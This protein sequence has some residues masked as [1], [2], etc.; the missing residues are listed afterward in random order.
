MKKLIIIALTI[1]FASCENP[2]IRPKYVATESIE[3]S[4]Y[5]KYRLSYIQDI[6]DS[7]KVKL[8]AWI[9]ETM[10]ASSSHLSAGDYED[11]EDLIEEINDIG[12]DLF[13]VKIDVL[14]ILESTN[15][16]W[17]TIEKDQMTQEQVTIFNELKP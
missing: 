2:M 8:A 10:R 17:R 9:T 12:K 3:V 6:P 15:G 16:S 11:P 14:E 5:P 13:S 4:E 1:V 7:N